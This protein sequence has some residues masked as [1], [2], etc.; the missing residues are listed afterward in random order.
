MLWFR[1][2][3]GYPAIKEEDESEETFR[4]ARKGA[5]PDVLSKLEERKSEL[6]E[7]RYLELKRKQQMGYFESVA[8]YEAHMRK[9]EQEA[10]KRGVE[11]GIRKMKGDPGM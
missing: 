5:D 9:T 2:R 4:L 8:Q 10:F 1:F 11:E 7:L 3:G 6:E